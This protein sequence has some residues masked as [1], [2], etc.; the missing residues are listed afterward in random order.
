[1]ELPQVERIFADSIPE[2]VRLGSESWR[3]G[4]S[5][6]LPGM[7]RKPKIRP[8]Q[9]NIPRMP[10]KARALVNLSSSP[11]GNDLPA[12]PRRPRSTSS[13]SVEVEELSDGDSL[14][15][16]SSPRRRSTPPVVPKAK[17]VG[18]KKKA[19]GMMMPAVF[20]RKAQADLKLMEQE[21]LHG[22]RSDSSVNSGDDDDEDRGSEEEE[23]HR[24]RAT[25]RLVPRMRDEP[26]KLDGDAFTDEPGEDEGLVMV[27]ATSEDEDEAVNSWL[28]SF[29]PRNHG[30][31]VGGDDIIDRFLRQAKRGSAG[32]AQPRGKTGR[33]KSRKQGHD[34]GSKRHGSR[35]RDEPR[36]Y[37]STSA[38]LP[39]H[40]ARN[41]SH[42]LPVRRNVVSLDTDA[43]I[44][45]FSATLR[46]PARSVRAGSSVGP[47]EVAGVPGSD[48]AED[49]ERWASFGKFSHDFEI[50]PL[51]AGL[52]FPLSSLSRQGHLTTLLSPR[53][54]VASLSPLPCTCNGLIFNSSLSPDD[55]TAL[56]PTLCDIIFDITAEEGVDDAALRSESGEALRFIGRYVSSCLA[57]QDDPRLR[58]RFGAAL[59][60]QLDRLCGRLDSLE[61]SLDAEGFNRA[62]KS[63]RISLSWYHLDITIRLCAIETEEREEHRQRTT[64]LLVGLVRRL[65]AFG[66][67]HTTKA[68]KL[69]MGPLAAEQ[70]LVLDDTGVEAWSCVINLALSGRLV[71]IGETELWRIVQEEV[72]GSLSLTVAASR[73]PIAG[74]VLS[75]TAM[76]LC[77]I[78]QFDPSGLALPTPRLSAHWNILLRALEP[79]QPS[80]LAKSDHSISN[81]A[82]AR[83]DRY[84]W[85]LFARCL[86][87]VGRWGWRVDPRDALLPKLFDI[88]N[89]RSL[90]NLSIEPMGDF[91]LFLQSDQGMREMDCRLNQEGDT[92]FGIFLKLLVGATRGIVYKS[93]SDRQRQL[94]K[95]FLRF[96]PMRSTAWTSRSVEISRSA[97][98]LINHYS[99]FLTFAL[100]SPQTCTQRLNQAENLIVFSDVNEEARRNCIR[101][102]LYFA[103]IY[104]SHS[105][106]LKSITIWL[107]KIVTQLRVECGE[108]EKERVAL[109]KGTNAQGRWPTKSG[110]RNPLWSRAVLL[111][112]VMRSVQL[113]LRVETGS[114]VIYPDIQLVHSGTSSLFPLSDLIQTDPDSL[115]G[116]AAQLSPLS[117]PDDWPRNYQIPLLL[118]RHPTLCPPS[119][120][121]FGSCKRVGK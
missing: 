78:S 22:R 46:N 62:F 57:A 80:V 120:G 2:F 90:A 92:T 28:S 43:A 35:R 98:I 56:V 3:R 10:T 14:S 26:L 42:S 103:L 106:D 111:S 115:D 108:L 25:T 84:L 119:K 70:D 21:R 6:E 49:G 69:F 33:S 38:L 55:I 53:D 66:A 50:K 11:S 72:L 4:T 109:E 5:A 77:A 13:S 1:M 41:G 71:Y 52:V 117:R 68:L 91:P 116:S 61:H 64:D 107:A 79:I 114:E 94:T 37:A 27:P 45:D 105:I 74:E 82:L 51:P 67:E 24:N 18:K 48:Q 73:G 47:K 99:L 54:A 30:D 76:M 86:T 20:M 36:P 16:S 40:H 113:I 96:S 118:S 32:G 34:G 29:A 85:V 17:L 60:S 95:L 88:V 39:V 89:A 44:F 102:I 112:M 83:R 19:L 8:Q 81:T 110:E 59:E 93:E 121:Y 63:R 15:G 104:R 97:S 9:G 101:A 75:Y 65:L 58:S 31:S 87:F 100:L 12:P 7:M 23:V